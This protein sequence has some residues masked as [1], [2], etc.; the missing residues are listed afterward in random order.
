MPF[1]DVVLGDKLSKKQRE[2]LKSGIGQLISI[3]PEKSE[4]NLMLRITDGNQLYFRGEEH[5][6]GGYMHIKLHHQAPME[7]KEKLIEQL[8]EMYQ[9]Q[10]GYAPE[11]MYITI[12]EFD[13]WGAIGK[14]LP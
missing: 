9:K 12:E 4:E 1:I 7:L 14:Y 11:D 5:H 13:H 10:L 8:F 2:T 6:C 3:I